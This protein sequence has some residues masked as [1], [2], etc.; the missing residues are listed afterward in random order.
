M[1]SLLENNLF[2]LVSFCFVTKGLLQYYIII[3]QLSELKLLLMTIEIRNPI[4]I[5]Y[6]ELISSKDLSKEIKLSIGSDNALGILLVKDI[7]NYAKLRQRLLTIVPKLAALPKHILA[8]YEVPEANWWIGWSHGKELRAS[9][10][11]PDVNKGSFYFNPTADNPKVNCHT[12]IY[13]SQPNVWPKEIDDFEAACKDLAKLMVFVG[14]LIARQCDKFC[15]RE[16]ENYAKGTIESIV[17]TGTCHKAR[18]LHYFPS[19]EN[20]NV[21]QDNLCGWHLDNSMLTALTRP[22]YNGS[23]GSLESDD[24]GLFIKT[25]DGTVSSVSIPSDCLAFQT[26]EALQL[27]T[28]ELIKATPHCVSSSLGLSHLSRNTLAIFMQPEGDFK[29]KNDYTFDEL[30]Q[31][32]V[33]R[34][35]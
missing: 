13:L 8:K 18:A 27:Y 14:T 22:L 31:D 11:K 28:N 32:V 34:H 33:K 4:I 6:R 1:Q 26:G 3:V 20:N 21:D 12:S 2:V 25:R 16:I 5:D 19:K 17:A 15:E 9:D 10:K 35:H 29:L 24:C 30:C 7:P 23:T